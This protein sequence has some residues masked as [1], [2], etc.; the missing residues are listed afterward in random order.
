MKIKKNAIKLLVLCSLVLCIQVPYSQAVISSNEF[1]Y[2]HFYYEDGYEFTNDSAHIV[3][4]WYDGGI[5]DYIRDHQ[6][7]IDYELI[8]A[9]N[10]DNYEHYYDVDLTE[11]KISIK[12]NINNSFQTIVDVTNRPIESIYKNYYI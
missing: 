1:P 3:W 5:D 2:F 11:F 9:Y 12:N 6:S 4:W 8:D 10:P 7:D